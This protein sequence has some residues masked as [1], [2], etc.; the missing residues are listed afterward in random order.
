MLSLNL[1]EKHTWRLKG[2]QMPL[3]DSGKHQNFKTANQNK[4]IKSNLMNVLN[5]VYPCSVLNLRHRCF[6]KEM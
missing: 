1:F 5:P 3:R 6:N 4:D 2:K